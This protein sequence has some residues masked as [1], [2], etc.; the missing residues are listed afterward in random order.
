MVV[1][2]TEQATLEQCMQT[3]RLIRE[4]KDG[5]ADG[6]DSDA[7]MDVDETDDDGTDDRQQGRKFRS[8]RR[9]KIKPGPSP[10]RNEY[11]SES[12]AVSQKRSLR[13]SSNRDSGPRS[14]NWVGLPAPRRDLRTN[15]QIALFLEK[16]VFVVCRCSYTI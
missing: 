4:G 2:F 15:M 10:L 5:N 8:R 11:I 16:Y 14:A 6:Y 1:H 13:T 9:T 7:E 3:S 12:L